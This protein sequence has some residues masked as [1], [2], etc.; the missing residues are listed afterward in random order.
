MSFRG[1]G[2]VAPAS[3]RRFCIAARVQKIAGG[4]PA[5]RNPNL[6]DEARDH[7]TDPSIRREKPRLN[8]CSLAASFSK[9]RPDASFIWDFAVAP[10]RCIPRYKLAK[11]AKISKVVQTRQAAASGRPATLWI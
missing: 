11:E 6:D 5:L 8:A 9:F 1:A 4:T 3:R 10:R 7:R 2:L